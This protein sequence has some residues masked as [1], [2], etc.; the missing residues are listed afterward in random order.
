MSLPDSYFDVA[1]AAH[2]AGYRVMFLRPEWPTRFAI[3]RT[4]AAVAAAAYLCDVPIRTRDPDVRAEARE[5]H[6]RL[7]STEEQRL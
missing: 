3:F 4:A 7:I 1:P 5:R 2:D 6:V